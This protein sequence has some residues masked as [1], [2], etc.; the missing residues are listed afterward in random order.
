M[1]GNECITSI[2]KWT[3]SWLSTSIHPACTHVSPTSVFSLHSSAAWHA[4]WLLPVTCSSASRLPQNVTVLSLHGVELSPA[5]GVNVSKVAVALSHL[6]IMPPLGVSL[7]NLQSADLPLHGSV[8]LTS[9]DVIPLP[10]VGRVE[11]ISELDS[12]NAVIHQAG[13]AGVLVRGSVSEQQ[14]DARLAG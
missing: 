7:T 1:H 2:L 8:S 12:G 5:G 9:Y 6:L 4:T 3:L 11:L 10:Y 13:P 14:G